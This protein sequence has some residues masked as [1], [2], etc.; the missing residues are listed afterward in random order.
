MVS[1]FAAGVGWLTKMLG[2]MPVE[3]ARV[4][5]Q[6][7][8][9]SEDCTTPVGKGQA[10][11]PKIPFVAQ[12]PFPLPPLSI[13]FNRSARDGVL[14]DVEEMGATLERI[15]SEKREV[16]LL[17]HPNEEQYITASSFPHIDDTHNPTFGFISVPG[18][19]AFLTLRRA[20]TQALN[21]VNLVHEQAHLGQPFSFLP[22]GI[23]EKVAERVLEE[24]QDEEMEEGETQELKGPI[25]EGDYFT[26]IDTPG[27]LRLA[28]R[29]L[30]K[31][32]ILG[33]ASSVPQAPG[34]F[35]PYEA[36]YAQ[37]DLAI[38]MTFLQRF[39]GYCI[40]DVAES[41][42]E[43]NDLM[44]SWIG[45]LAKTSSGGKMAHMMKCLEIA[46]QGHNGLYVVTRAN[47][48]YDGCVILGECSLKQVGMKLVEHS[49]SV[50]L[51]QEL[52]TFGFHSVVLRKVL[53]LVKAD[54]GLDV[55]GMRELRG[56]IMADGM[57]GGAV[58]NQIEKL[59]PKLAFDEGPLPVNHNTIRSTL[60]LLTST[61][62]IPEDL[63]LGFEDVFAEDRT[64]LVLASFGQMVPSFSPGGIRL[65]VTL[66]EAKGTS[67]ILPYSPTPPQVLQVKVLPIAAAIAHWNSTLQ[68]GIIS[69]SVKER[70]TGS[71]VF[72]GPIKA[73][74][75]KDLNELLDRTIIQAQPP[76]PAVQDRVKRRRED[77]GDANQRLRKVSKMFL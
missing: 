11:T 3:V 30:P 73:T 25:P 57:P 23:V 52:S 38:I 59:L 69:T 19:A 6:A 45:E 46:I 74:L 9:I 22:G 65:R 43:T 2:N 49:S 32:P 21:F 42:I 50:M 14:V 27:T 63:Y 54:E 76:T 26:G 61:D 28:F 62:V 17:S 4:V 68:T 18:I 37:T 67:G 39:R 66:K 34:I 60:Q 71:R 53:H 47:R 31:H 8:G 55:R 72:S 7:V 41:D 56:L 12:V 15:A 24:A 5:D 64:R 13:A 77:D 51:E 58:R 70:I 36:N 16:Y 35:I 40:E 1:V 44:Y 10:Y 75:W 20:L 29:K 33:N 48:D